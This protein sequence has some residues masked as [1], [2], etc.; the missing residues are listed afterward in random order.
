[1]DEVAGKGGARFLVM[2]QPNQPEISHPSRL[3]T[4][5]RTS[6]RLEGIPVLDLG[7]RYRARGLGPE[8]LLLDYQGHLSPFGHRV[9]VQEIETW[10]ASVL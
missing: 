10:L 3:S 6:L 2:L 4:R 7:E 8:E 9:A 1:M 5:L